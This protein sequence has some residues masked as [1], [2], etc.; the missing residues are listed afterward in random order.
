MH[1]LY[2]GVF[3]KFCLLLFSKARNDRRQ[4]WSLYHKINSIDEGLASVKIPTT[5]SR[6]FRTIKQITRF[7][8]NEFRS[9]MHHGS[10]VLLQAMQPRYRRH[11]ALLLAAINTAS[12]DVIH[13][14]DV[15]LIE[16]SLKKFVEGWQHIFGLRQMSSNIHSLLHVHQSVRFMGP[17][18]MYSTF[19]FEGG[20]VE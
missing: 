10:T 2:L 17:L 20:F 7:K 14:C 19:N 3:K 4:K 18:Y 11:F 6:R 12:K 16:S 5:T 13:H 1:T 15:L 8:A 9:L